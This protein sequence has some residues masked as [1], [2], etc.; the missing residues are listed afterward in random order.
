MDGGTESQK[1]Q[2]L[3][4]PGGAEVERTSEAAAFKFKKL[5]SE[6]LKVLSISPYFDVISNI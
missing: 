6:N 3:A 1:T 2:K 4:E 5:A